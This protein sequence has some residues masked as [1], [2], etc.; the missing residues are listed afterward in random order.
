MSRIKCTACAQSTDARVPHCEFCG[1]VHDEA[2]A[3]ALEEKLRRAELAGA[4]NTGAEVAVP[5]GL[6]RGE[7]KHDQ[8]A[9]A[10]LLLGLG[11]FFCIPILG[12]F[13]IAQGCRVNAALTRDG[14]PW[15]GF[16]I[17][18]VV[19]GVLS[20]LSLIAGLVIMVMF[21]MTGPGF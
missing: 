21:V 3:M 15:N 16:A 8:A 20:T 17:A 7:T 18:G 9:S 14:L 4:R 5:T 19:L 1:H 10:A 6:Y 13:A 11:G 12:P 2:G